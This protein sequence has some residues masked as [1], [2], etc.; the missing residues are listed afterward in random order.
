[1]GVD[2]E[3]GGDVAMVGGWN[4]R[5]QV[6]I[7]FVF[8]WCISVESPQGVVGS[9]EGRLV[10]GKW[11]M[12]RTSELMREGSQ[13]RGCVKA[14]QALGNLSIIGGSGVMMHGPFGV[15]DRGAF[16]PPTLTTT[17]YNEKR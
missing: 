3:G 14:S 5:W 10:W 17:Y 4:R 16:G 1:M 6:G 9:G 15:S 11:I 7:N 2:I 8:G 12:R 13:E